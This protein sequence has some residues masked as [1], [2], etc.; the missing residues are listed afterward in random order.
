MSRDR[1]P[2]D[3]AASMRFGSSAC[4]TAQMLE[5]SLDLA[6]GVKPFAEV[7]CIMANDLS[8]TIISRVVA[9]RFREAS[10]GSP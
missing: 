7:S 5:A 6:L 9:N 1:A 4:T 8:C 3:P 10:I 2:N